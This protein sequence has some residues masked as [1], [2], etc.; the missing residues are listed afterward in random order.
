MHCGYIKIEVTLEKRCSSVHINHKGNE[1]TVGLLYFSTPKSILSSTTTC[2][3]Y[4]IEQI[5]TTPTTTKLIMLNQ[6]VDLLQMVGWQ[7]AVLFLVVFFIGLYW[8]QQPVNLPPGPTGWPVVGCALKVKSGETH[9]AFTNWSKQYGVVF[10]VRLGPQ[11]FV[12]L[13]DLR[14][15]KK[16]LH[17]QADVFSDRLVVDFA[18]L[19][20]VEGIHSF[21]YNKQPVKFTKCTLLFSY[22]YIIFHIIMTIHRYEIT[23]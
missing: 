8:I 18:K 20:G 17:E 22:Q 6:I 16:A 1:C 15:I 5:S 14:S 9:I 13:N 23:E 21:F 19:L 3:I 2:K 12:V 10:S 4:R 11:L 7:T